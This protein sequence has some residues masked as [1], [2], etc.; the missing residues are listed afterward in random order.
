MGVRVSTT[1][2]RPVVPS[3]LRTETS[4]RGHELHEDGTFRRNGGEICY[5]WT[6][7]NGECNAS[8]FYGAGAWRGRALERPCGA[9][10]VTKT[11]EQRELEWKQRERET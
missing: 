7:V 2:D 11:R 8:L 3:E 10:P 5:L 6:C 4:L 1:G 9:V